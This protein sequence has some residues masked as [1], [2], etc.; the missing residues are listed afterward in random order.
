MLRK[1]PSWEK[2]KNQNNLRAYPAKTRRCG[3]EG[4]CALV[5]VR[6]TPPPHCFF[7]FLIFFGWW[8]ATTERPR[9]RRGCACPRPLPRGRKA[10]VPR[11]KVSRRAA[12]VTSKRML[13]TA[14]G[15]ERGDG[16]G[17]GGYAGAE[18]S[19]NLL[20]KLRG[21]DFFCGFFF[22]SPPC[23]LRM[24]VFPARPWVPPPPQNTPPCAEVAG[25]GAKRC[26]QGVWGGGGNTY[27]HG[28]RG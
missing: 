15:W 28:R 8:G 17:G 10:A 25:I 9:L 20:N 1:T 22:F 26:S 2:K 12:K 4:A 16:G 13:Q 21:R 7:F 14:K 3:R 11:P 24:G 23:S 27:T 5:A 18:G 6:V 19:V